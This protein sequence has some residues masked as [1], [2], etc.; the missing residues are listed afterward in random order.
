MSV[1]T[2]IEWTHPPGFTGATWNAVS[3]CTRVS[4]GCDNCYAVK[5]THRLE[6]MGHSKYAGLT[7]LNK[8]GDRHFNGK[9]RTHEDTLDIPMRRRIPTCYFVNSMSDLFHKEVPFEFIDRCFAVMALCPQHRFLILTKR[10]E[11]M[12]EYLGTHRGVMGALT[13]DRFKEA[14][15]HGAVLGSAHFQ[16]PGGDDAAFDWPL[17]NVWLGTSTEDQATAYERIPHL[18]R[19]PATVRFLSVEP[20]L[21]PIDLRRVPNTSPPM[22]G[23]PNGAPSRRIDWV[24]QGGE[25]GIGARPFDISWAHSLRDQCKAAGV[26]YF[27]KQLGKW[28]SG[29]HEFDG[30]E[31]KID[32]WQLKAAS[33]EMSTHRRPILRADY[34]P[35]FYDERPSNAI[36]FGFADQKGGNPW[37]WPDDLR[38]REWPAQIIKEARPA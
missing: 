38:V 35:K 21:G 15:R 8:A 29:S 12:A 11:R 23:C 25:S 7:V 5:M 9:V 19:C 18:L 30:W 27:L 28:V 10:P 26:A 6:K 16:T 4:A 1:G 33:G 14:G 22:P 34:S 36:A 17:P 20:Q 2:N 37:D 3:G 31:G 13:F 24:I 32:R